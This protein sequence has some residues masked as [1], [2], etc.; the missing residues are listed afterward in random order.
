M[1]ATLIGSRKSDS[2]KTGSKNVILT[3]IRPVSNGVQLKRSC[4]EENSVVF[5]KTRPNDICSDA[6]D[7]NL[8]ESRNTFKIA[9][10]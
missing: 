5:K 3:E 7:N 1:L 4:P 10:W 2:K 9:E 8:F 6:G